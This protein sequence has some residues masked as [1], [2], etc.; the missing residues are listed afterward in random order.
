[1]A[2]PWATR[3]TVTLRGGPGFGPEEEE[4]SEDSWG[5]LASV[6]IADVTV[7][8]FSKIRIDKRVG[9]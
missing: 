4:E 1:M 2:Y 6:L 9:D 5:E 3:V 7:W 8:L